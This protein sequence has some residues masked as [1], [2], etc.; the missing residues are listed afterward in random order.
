MDVLRQCGLGTPFSKVTARIQGDRKTIP[1]TTTLVNA[2]YA[3]FCQKSIQNEHK[4]C[5]KGK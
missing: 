2:R 1:R 3:N 5:T 4:E